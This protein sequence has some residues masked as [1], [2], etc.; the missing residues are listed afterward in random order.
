MPEEITFVGA[1]AGSNTSAK[2]LAVSRDGD[3]KLTL[4]IPASELAAI[5]SILAWG[6]TAIVFTARPDS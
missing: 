2:C 3:A 6:E 4:E 1:L 5:L